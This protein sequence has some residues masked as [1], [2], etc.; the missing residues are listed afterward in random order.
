MAN[1][2]RDGGVT[3]TPPGPARPTGPVGPAADAGVVSLPGLYLMLFR[4]ITPVLILILQAP[5]ARISSPTETA[6][7]T[8]AS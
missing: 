8:T 5:P 3:Q 7:R 4:L 2:A 6:T 1:V